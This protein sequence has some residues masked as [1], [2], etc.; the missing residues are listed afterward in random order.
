MKIGN[1]PSGGRVFAQAHIRNRYI[2][3]QDGEAQHLITLISCQSTAGN[4]DTMLICG[5][6]A[7]RVISV[8]ILADSL[9]INT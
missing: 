9:T 8:Y 2:V 1:G 4:V 3:F 7:I 6:Q 5:E